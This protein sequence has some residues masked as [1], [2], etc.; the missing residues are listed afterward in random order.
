MNILEALA[1][2]DVE[3][4]DDWTNQGLPKTDII[5][6]V[7]GEP[8]TR[9]QITEAAPN[10]TRENP[11]MEVASVEPEVPAEPGTDPDQDQGTGDEATGDGVA[12]SETPEP[13]DEDD[14]E[15]ST[16]E[17]VMQHADNFEEGLNSFLEEMSARVTASFDPEGL[18]KNHPEVLGTA[19]ALT[20]A[21]KL[22][23]VTAK[24]VAKAS[25]DHEAAVQ[26]HAPLTH[27]PEQNQRGIMDHIAK[28][29]ARKEAKFTE[30]KQLNAAMASVGNPI[31]R[32][33]AKK[34][35]NGVGN[36]YTQRLHGQGGN[37]S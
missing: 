1:S 30:A 24:A 17:Q 34:P 29:L 19:V 9:A 7:V 32:A 20:V 14:V 3:N 5:S 8:I 33:N 25:K 36:A 23:A 10:F 12:T 37:V 35:D 4:D 26:K 21:E 27:T 22:K 6:D 11:V 31:D 28:G 18:D 13:S 16:V 2:L 15:P